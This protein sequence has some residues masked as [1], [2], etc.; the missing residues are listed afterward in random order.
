MILILR[1]LTPPAKNMLAL[2][3]LNRAKSKHWQIG[4]SLHACSLSTILRQAH[5]LQRAAAGDKG[6]SLAIVFE[7]HADRG[8]A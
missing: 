8:S 4:Y 6:V 3:G 1:W 5:G 2:P 7:L